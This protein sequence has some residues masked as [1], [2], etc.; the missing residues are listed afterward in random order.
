MQNFSPA[1]PHRV[2]ASITPAPAADATDVVSDIT[3]LTLQASSIPRL[4]SHERTVVAR[5][6]WSQTLPP[7]HRVSPPSGPLVTF[8]SLTT[9]R[10]TCWLNDEV[11][12]AYMKLLSRRDDQITQLTPGRHHNHCFS[13]HFY[14]L[15]TQ[16]DVSDPVLQGRVNP[17]LVTNWSNT[18]P[19]RTL[20][21]LHRLC[22]PLNPTGNH[23]TGIIVD[24]HAHNI[25]Y[26]DTLGSDGAQH[27]QNIYLYLQSEHR[28]QH[29]T[30]PPI[31]WHLIP[32]DTTSVPQQPN[33]FDCGVYCCAFIDLI[34]QNLPLQLSPADVAAYRLRMALAILQD[35]AAILLP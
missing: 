8:A 13:S 30:D 35:A 11:I 27:L 18:L 33:G 2:P 28:R 32:C 34:L 9:L 5:V 31:M 26:L 10:P 15:L 19:T 24:F 1:Y 6:L 29:P 21:Q 4:T 25:R 3:E 12:D 20:F 22:I 17:A 14:S 23:W 7:T 16:R